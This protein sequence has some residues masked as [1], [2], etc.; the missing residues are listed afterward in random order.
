MLH[1]SFC[2]LDFRCVNPF[3]FFSPKGKSVVVRKDSLAGGRLFAS[4]LAIWRSIPGCASLPY[5]GRRVRSK[6]IA[7]SRLLPVI[8]QQ[9]GKECCRESS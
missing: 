3:G 8:D 1:F 2:V 6:E 4:P 9:K 7:V 5:I